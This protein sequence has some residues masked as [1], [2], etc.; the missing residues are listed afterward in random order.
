[1]LKTKA[2]KKFLLCIS[3]I[4]HEYKSKKITFIKLPKKRKYIGSEI[5]AKINNL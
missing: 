3:K 2:T 1:M 4:K 5:T